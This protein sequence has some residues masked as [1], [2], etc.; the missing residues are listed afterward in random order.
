MMKCALE[1]PECRKICDVCRNKCRNRR[2]KFTGFLEKQWVH[3]CCHI[4]FPRSC[5]DGKH[6]NVSSVSR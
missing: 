4:G 1:R 5:Y 3:G 2:E 6:A